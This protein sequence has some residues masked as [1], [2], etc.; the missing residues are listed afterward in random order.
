MFI[1]S[2]TAWIFPKEQ[3]DTHQNMEMTSMLVLNLTYHPKIPKKDHIRQNT[4]SLDML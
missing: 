4:L 1:Q 2:P 3:H